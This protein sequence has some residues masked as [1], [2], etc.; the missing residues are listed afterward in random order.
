M[1]LKLDRLLSLIVVVACIV[2]F[3][4]SMSG[5]MLEPS[6]PQLIN[7]DTISLVHNHVA[8]ELHVQN[9]HLDN[10]PVPTTPPIR[11]SEP[12]VPAAVPGYKVVGEDLLVP[13]GKEKSFLFIKT[14][15]CGTSTMVNM[16]YLYG[17]RR[18]L[19]FVTQPW[20]RGLDVEL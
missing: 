20:Q 9:A 7:R 14:H 16:L 13:T 18:R 11:N 12:P 8:A 3:F 5:Y 2:T 10:N 15:K 4:Y 19:N 1:R 6:T 17:I